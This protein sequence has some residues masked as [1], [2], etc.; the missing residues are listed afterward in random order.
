MKIFADDVAMY[1]YSVESLSECRTGFSARLEFGV[2][3][4]TS[5][6]KFVVSSY[7]AILVMLLQSR[8]RSEHS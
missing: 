4:V 1:C 5:K 6:A 7:V 2:S 8:K 3:F